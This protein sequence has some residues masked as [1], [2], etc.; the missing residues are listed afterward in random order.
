MVE[1][2]DAAEAMR[3]CDVADRSAFRSTLG[4]TMCKSARHFEAFE[5]AFEV[6]FGLRAPPETA[7]AERVDRDGMIISGGA[8]GGVGD[9][10]GADLLAAALAR[11]LRED[12]QMLL[13]AVVRRAVDLLAGMEPGRPVGGTYYLYRILRRLQIDD[14]VERLVAEATDAGQLASLE[15]RLLREEIEL[16]VEDL[17]SRLRSEIRMRLV[18]DRGPEA[19]ARTLRRPLVEDIDLMHATRIELAEVERVVHPLARKLATRLAQLR[20]QG[21]GGRLDV[22]RTLR[23]SLSAGG[24]LIDPQF[25]LPRPSKP[26]IFLL[27]DISGSVATFAR[28]T[29][30]LTYALGHQFSRVRSFAFIDDIDEVTSF[31]APGADFADALR[32]VSNEAR[33]VWLDGHSDYGRCLQRFW[34]TWGRELTA[35][36]TVI[37]VGDA[38]SNYHDANGAALR[39]IAAA[40]RELFWLNPEARRYWNTGDSVMETYAAVCDAVYEV[41]N[42]RQLEAFVERVATPTHRQVR[43]VS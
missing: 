17:R 20:R 28:F 2:I 15:Q 31:F 24:A 29:M 38:R 21:R 13:E 3:H 8:G 12:D 43:R 11:A 16:R 30:Q 19:V 9:G 32:Q 23:R 33:V 10:D 6:F 34:E 1:V 26:E 35:K 14:M 25:R 7:D 27:C 36:S 18:A 42:L 4:A 39:E 5:V 41:R 37:I 40:A 22:R